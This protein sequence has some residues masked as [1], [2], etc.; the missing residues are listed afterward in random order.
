MGDVPDGPPVVPL[1]ERLD[2]RLRLG[3]FPS[4]RDALKFVTY[5]AAGAVAA[6][7]TSPFLWLAVVAGGFA[8]CVVRSDGQAIDERAL[9]FVLWKLRAGSG[10][11]RVTRAATSRI[12]RE[13]FVAIRPGQYVAIVRTGGT[14]V[15]YLPPIELARRFELFRHLLRSVGGGLAFLVT[16]TAMPPGPVLPNPL[17]SDHSDQ[18]ARTGYGELVNLLCRRRQIRRVYLALS[19]ERT[20]PDGLADLE[21]RV[22]ALIDRLA[23][24]GVRSVRL[25][26]RGLED[27]ARRWGWR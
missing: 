25:R 14:P 15:T 2:R 16:S 4:A 13:G 12:T 20:G 9:A 17:R 21:L 26:D 27:A 19:V 24:L 23:S 7:F 5:A 11:P 10:G 22:A 8:V 3:P 1:P 6:P 18:A